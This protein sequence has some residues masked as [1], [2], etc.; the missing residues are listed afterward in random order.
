M[1]EQQPLI[2]FTTNQ[3]WQNKH[4]NVSATIE[5][6][7]EA[8]NRWSDRSQ[9]QRD[10]WQPGLSA[11]QQIVRD[12]EASGKRVRGLGGGWSLSEA[13][14]TTDF[15]V[16]TKQL[17]NLV[18]GISP[19]F[20]N[21]SFQ[22]DP[23]RLVFAQCGVSVMELNIALETRHLSLP[24]S[25]ASNG[26][27]ICGAVST[28]THGSAHAFGAMQEFVVGLHIVAEGGRHY[29]VERASQ[30][31]VGPA[32]AEFL[33][34]ELVRDTPLFEAALVSVGSF[35]LIHAVLLVCEPIYTL[36]LHIRRYDYDQ[37]QP[38]LSTLDVRTLHLPDGPTL[39]F[40]FEAVLNPYRTHAGEAGTFVRF[41]YKRPFTPVPTIPGDTIVTSPGDDVMG[42]IGTLSD[43]VPHLIPAAL[44]AF[45]PRQFP[46]TTAPILGSHGQ[47]F[48]ATEVRGHAMSTEIGVALQDAGAAV[49]AIVAVAHDH[50][51]ASPIAVRYVKASSA[52]LAFTCFAPITCTIELPAVGSPRT[53]EAYRRIW[54]ELDRRGIPYTLHWGQCLR[55]EAAFIRQAFG[56]RVDAWLAARRQFLSPAARRT[57][58]NDLLVACGLAD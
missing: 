11:L 8:W 6:L 41:I 48:G 27:T 38:A 15:L 42:L 55:A 43:A 36:E 39:P 51:F 45:L 2:Q 3:A 1:A 40:H 5:R 54:A 20:L 33:G 58:A 31:V 46:P 32:F 12:A 37:V 49:E 50:A 26:Q 9:P 53:Q 52:T 18:I 22:G 57:F 16:D 44:D 13:A 17:N 35:G 28:G 29:W 19:A 34:A 10:V 56:A 25:G 23:G 14:V 7:Y 21:A 30:P 4:M 47:I 24:T